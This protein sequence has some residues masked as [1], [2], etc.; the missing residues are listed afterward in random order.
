MKKNQVATYQISETFKITGRGIVFAGFI[1]DGV[2]SIGDYIE[3]STLD[4]VLK[5]KIAGV[6][7]IRSFQPTKVNT[8]LLIKCEN[9]QE[10]EELRNWEPKNTVATVLK[11]NERIKLWADFNASSDF[12]LRLN[13]NGTLKD[14]EKRNLILEEGMELLLWGEDYNEDD[15]RDDLIVVATARYNSK[16]SIWEG[17]FDWNEIRHESELKNNDT[18]TQAKKS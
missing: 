1:M 14:L 7:G 10:I 4:K 16:R 12:G 17:E 18:T 3:F 15:E 6:E 8:G 9:D 11:I 5:R 13:C 2:V